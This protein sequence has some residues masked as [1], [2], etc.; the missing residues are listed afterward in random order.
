MKGGLS[1]GLLAAKKKATVKVRVGCA[2]LWTEAFRPPGGIPECNCRV[3]EQLCIEGSQALSFQSNC[4][5]LH[6]SHRVEFQQ[7]HILAHASIVV[8]MS[9]GYCNN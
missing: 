2:G 9:Q 7:L 6:S 1:G 4:A 5:V 8:L 3:T